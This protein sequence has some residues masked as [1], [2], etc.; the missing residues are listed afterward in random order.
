MTITAAATRNMAFSKSAI[1][2]ITRA[3]ALPDGGDSADDRISMV[4]PVSGI[5]FEVSVY[6]Q[7]RRIKYEVAAAW[8]VKNTAPRHT[9]L[10]LG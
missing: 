5:N 7:Y 1:Q 4:D 3:P 9:A 8:G 2:L 6:R 10:L